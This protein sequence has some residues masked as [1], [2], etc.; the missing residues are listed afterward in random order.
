[1]V[2]KK[3]VIPNTLG[4]HL[5]PISVLCNEAIKYKCTV[6]IRTDH[7]EING[8]SV[9]GALSACIR[10]Q[11]EIELV[12]DGPDELEALNELSTMIENGLGDKL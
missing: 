3:I 5:R 1:M 8:K 12:C 9:I 4:L 7:K 2:S 6:L 11:D 10:Y